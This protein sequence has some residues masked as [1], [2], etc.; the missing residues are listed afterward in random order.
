[1]LDIFIYAFNAVASILIIIL[2][3]YFLK[4][5]GI[6]DD[7]FSHK[8]NKFCFRYCLPVQLFY[9]VYNI[10]T[11][12]LIDLKLLVLMA[13]YVSFLFIVGLFVAPIISKENKR[14][15]VITMCTFRSNTAIM[16]MP[17]ATYLGGEEAAT[18]LALIM[19]VTI[20][21][22]N[23]YTVIAFMI[24]GD[25]DKNLS[26]K[27]AI[28][29]IS[30]NPLI[31]GISV[32]IICLLFRQILPFT[33][34]DNL[35]PL[36]NAIK[37]YSAIASPLLLLVLGA[38][39][40]LSNLKLNKELIWTVLIRLVLAPVLGFVLLFVCGLSFVSLTPAIYQAVCAA[41]T[42]PAPVSGTVV[43]A[44]LGGEEKF[45]SSAVIL[46]TIISPLTIFIFV[47]AL[48]YLSLI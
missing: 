28:K 47:V 39:S 11:A 38:R 44:E 7:E 42:T 36:Y 16:G 32:G 15:S 33:I 34:K 46:S 23:V 25:E 45:A 20:I 48:R 35:S 10:D 40:D 13:V 41:I 18:I 26:F 4:R 27:I 17:M 8:L 2:F 9:N 12:N 21:L 3:G 5:K 37:S 43:T 19:A 6:I 31:I 22:F 1:M 30:K 29:E 24:Y 14:R